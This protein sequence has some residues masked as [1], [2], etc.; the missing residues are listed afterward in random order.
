M[1]LDKIAASGDLGTQRAAR[2]KLTEDLT[3]QRFDRGEG[4]TP[5]P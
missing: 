1:D 5:C 4:V 2:F 3:L